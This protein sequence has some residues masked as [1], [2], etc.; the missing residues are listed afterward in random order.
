MSLILIDSLRCAVLFRVDSSDQP[1]AIR[2]W[3]EY[4]RGGFSVLLAHVGAYGHG[5]QLARR[6]RRSDAPTEPSP[7]KSAAQSLHGPQL[8]SNARRS[9]AAAVP[10]SSRAHGHGRI[11]SIRSH[12]TENP[13]PL[14]VQPKENRPPLDGRC[15]IH[16]FEYVLTSVDAVR[17]RRRRRRDRLGAWPR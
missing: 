14:A 12:R 9:D 3:L 5:P 6:A 2:N 10:S 7:S 4:Q 11:S 8:A 15:F 13:A 17:R 16:T 1:I